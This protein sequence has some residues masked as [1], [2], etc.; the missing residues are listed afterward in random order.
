MEKKALKNKSTLLGHWRDIVKTLFP[1]EIRLEKDIDHLAIIV[2]SARPYR[3]IRKKIRNGCIPR[4]RRALPEKKERIGRQ[5]EETH[6][7]EIQS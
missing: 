2:R 3:R 6:W 5:I 4:L 1:P 7:N